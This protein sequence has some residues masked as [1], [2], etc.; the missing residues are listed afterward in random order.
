MGHINLLLPCYNP[1]AFGEV[2][3]LLNAKCFR[4]NK[5]RAADAMI[6][7][8][9]EV[10]DLL[11]M[12]ELEAAARLDPE[13]PPHIITAGRRTGATT[14][15]ARTT[16]TATTTTTT[17]ASD[18]SDDSSDNE[19]DPAA[20]DD[21][22]SGGP[23]LPQPQRHDNTPS[24]V[25]AASQV[26]NLSAINEYKEKVGRFLPRLFG[27]RHLTPAVQLR[28]RVMHRLAVTG[29][30]KHCKAFSPSVVRDP[31]NTKLFV[32][33]LRCVCAPV[34]SSRHPSA[35]RQARNLTNR[36]ALPDGFKAVPYAPGAG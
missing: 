32:K 21:D 13:L 14:H 24:G 4:C 2:R 3:R 25:A 26:S 29:A 17:N 33:A 16:S 15:T 18:V 22:A 30:C 6:N 19:G 5:F 9:V 12:G 34:G 27:A 35:Q 20:G 11:E 10:F 7:R 36:C 28:R 8:Y 31:T 1:Q 23:T